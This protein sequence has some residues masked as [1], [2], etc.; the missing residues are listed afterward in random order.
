VAVAIGRAF[1]AV[2]PSR[3]ALDAVAEVVGTMQGREPAFRWTR[4]DGWHLTM[5]FLDRVEDEAALVAAVAGA[6][7]GVVPV[8]VRLRSAGA[9][10]TARRARV[11]W[12]GVGQGADQLRALADGLDA[13]CAPLSD[14]PAEGGHFTPHL[15]IARLRAPAD[16]R[17][18]LA[19][20]DGPV[21]PAW[22]A[23]ELVLFE[24]RLHGAPPR[25]VPRA[26]FPLAGEPHRD[27]RGS[28][29]AHDG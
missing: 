25:Y 11:L 12:I 3:R 18:L 15:T 28:P 24:S 13:A 27:A 7:R 10:P 29:D 1:L 26:R 8:T 19:A 5:R 9:F 2:V 23:E 16:V 6:T 4:R 14:A 20:V 17:A 22:T 21:G